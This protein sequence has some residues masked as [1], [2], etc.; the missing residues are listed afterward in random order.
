M[1]ISFSRLNLF[2]DHELNELKAI[3]AQLD[4]TFYKALEGEVKV[5]C[6]DATVIRGLSYMPSKGKQTDI[7]VN[8]SIVYS[9]H[10]YRWHIL[11]K[12]LKIPQIRALTSTNLNFLFWKILFS[13]KNQ[14]LGHFLTQFEDKLDKRSVMIG[15]QS[16]QKQ[17]A[18]KELSE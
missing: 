1:S 12:V 18:A 4:E 3:N 16:L 14:L 5:T 11:E 2:F 9:S 17:L 13:R 8:K 6:F 10:L 7:F 15:K